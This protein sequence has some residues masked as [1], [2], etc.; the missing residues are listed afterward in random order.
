MEC[1]VAGCNFFLKAIRHEAFTFE[2]GQPNYI[3]SNGAPGRTQQQGQNP[4]GLQREAESL[5]P[6]VSCLASLPG[7][8][9]Q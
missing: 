8:I 5:Q 6:I 1:L 3:A 7:L 2:N 9:A 4:A